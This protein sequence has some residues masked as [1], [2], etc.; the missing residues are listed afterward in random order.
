MANT[1]LEIGVGDVV[2]LKH[3]K[4]EYPTNADVYIDGQRLCI[5]RHDTGDIIEITPS[6][7]VRVS[8]LLKPEGKAN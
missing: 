4:A 2:N 8:K 7:G 3:K 1:T 5:T 6:D